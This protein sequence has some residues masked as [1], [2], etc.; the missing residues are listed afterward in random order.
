LLMPAARRSPKREA[1]DGCSTKSALS[2]A[3][4]WDRF[5]V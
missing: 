2:W 4:D 5:G 3:T 1:N